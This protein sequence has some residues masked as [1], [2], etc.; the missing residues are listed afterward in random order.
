M[1]DNKFS[2]IPL[3][4]ADTYN[5]WQASFIAFLYSKDLEG[6]IDLD[7]TKFDSTKDDNKIKDSKH[8]YSYMFRTC[9]AHTK[10]ALPATCRPKAGPE[11]PR[12]DLLWAHLSNAFSASVGSR[13]AALFQA[14]YC[15]QVGEGQD[16]LSCSVWDDFDSYPDCFWR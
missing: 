9:S 2:D 1:S 4:N 3:C 13:Q 8:C 14:L 5:E 7:P 10:A 11:M 6:Y 16:P 12:P 15:T